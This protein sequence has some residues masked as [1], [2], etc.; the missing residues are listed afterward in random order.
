LNQVTTDVVDLPGDMLGGATGTGILIDV[1]AAGYGW[2][3]DSAITVSGTAV[4]PGR[5]DL[6]SVIQHE[7]GHLLG[8]EDLDADEHVDDLMS[9]TLESGTR[10]LADVTDAEW[11]SLLDELA[12]DAGADQSQVDQIFADLEDDEWWG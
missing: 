11:E 1:N 9:G 4:E 8:F 6:L 5:M 2:H 12:G 10:H 7:L 3:T